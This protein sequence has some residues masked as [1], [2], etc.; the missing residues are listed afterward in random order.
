MF[1]GFPFP[2]GNTSNVRAM[3]P[4]RLQLHEF[5]LQDSEALVSR[6][7]LLETV[8][9]KCTSNADFPLTKAALLQ[10][11]WARQSPL[12]LRKSLPQPLS[13]F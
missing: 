3:P 2:A 9:G 12:A 7:E 10:P 1:Y 13:R 8:V 5:A 11:Q 6:N 4:W